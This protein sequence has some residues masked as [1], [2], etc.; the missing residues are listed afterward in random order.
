[1][2]APTDFDATKILM[3]EELTDDEGKPRDPTEEENTKFRHQLFFTAFQAAYATPNFFRKLNDKPELQ[4]LKITNYGE[5]AQHA[6][7]QTCDMLMQ[8][9][10][11]EA[12]MGPA[13][14]FAK[15]YGAI[16]VFSFVVQ[17]N[18]TAE[19]KLLADQ[20]PKEKPEEGEAEAKPATD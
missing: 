16:F 10:W 13:F 9:P 3:G 8:F 15:K 20:E 7:D 2:D 12:L 6:S 14:E 5:L 18:V 19:K 4:S 1:M 11:F 17:Q